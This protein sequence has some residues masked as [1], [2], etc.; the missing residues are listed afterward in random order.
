VLKVPVIFVFENNHYSEHTGASYAVGSRDIAGRA[1]AFGMP[2]YRADGCDFFASYAAMKEAL[3][4]CRAGE[5]PVAIEFDTERFFGHFE[6]DPQRYRGPGEVNRLR[7][8]RDCLAHFRD[9][10]T[11]DLLLESAAL[12]RVD[13]EVARL[14]EEA[15]AEARSAP[16]PRPEEAL[17]DVYVEY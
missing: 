17:E 5:G 9:R 1:E 2:A 10:V 14:I 8:K 3:A 6:G 11:A 16:P 4:H 7:G 15:I 12:D 13:A